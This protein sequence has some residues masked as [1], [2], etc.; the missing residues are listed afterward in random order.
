[1][2]QW[3][4]NCGEVEYQG[5]Y[6]ISSAAMRELVQD[7]LPALPPKVQ[8]SGGRLK[9][10]D[11]IIVALILKDEEQF[12]DNWI[13]I[14]DPAVKV[15]RIQNFKSWSPEMV[16]DPSWN[17]LGLEYFCFEGDG[18]WSA[19]NEELVAV[20]KREIGHIG[21]INPARV[22]DAEVVRR[23]KA[24]PIYVDAYQAHVE[25]VRDE[26]QTV[27]PTLHLVGRNGMH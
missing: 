10:R 15:A 5:D 20:A 22:G 9:Y 17:C 4:V 7:Y 1:N 21:L 6:L 14:H 19:P 11:F 24:Y 23:P 16:P 27:Y 3:R 12:S 18:L 2:G 8:A 26:F 25:A 13:Y